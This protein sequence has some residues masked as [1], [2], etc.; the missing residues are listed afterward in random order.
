MVEEELEQLIPAY[1]TLRHELN[2]AEQSNILEAEEWA[3]TRKRDVL[4]EKLLDNLHKRMFGRVW[5]W[6]GKHRQS[7]KTIGI[8]AYRIPTELRQL[9]DDL[10]QHVEHEDL[11]AVIHIGPDGQALH[12]V[13]AVLG[14]EEHRHA[15]GRSGCPGLVAGRGAGLVA[16]A[17]V[18]L[19]LASHVPLGAFRVEVALGANRGQVVDVGLVPK[20]MA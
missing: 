2:E 14:L 9:L 5:R 1:I 3:F 6:A 13:F 19:S 12:Q 10:R 8:D 4:S 17:D 7:N 16:R 18:H 20:V 15:T 11:L